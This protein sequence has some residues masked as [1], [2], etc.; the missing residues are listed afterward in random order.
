MLKTHIADVL[1]GVATLR[2]EV[3]TLQ[4]RNA[5]LHHQLDVLHE[6]PAVSIQP[7]RGKRSNASAQALNAQVKK[8]NNEV[9]KLVKTRERDRKR[10]KELETR[11][12]VKDALEL[13]DEE[14]N[15]IDDAYDKMRKLLRRFFHLMSAPSLE[16]KEECIICWEVMSMESV[17]SLPCQHV[18]C[19]KCLSSLEKQEC[20][21]CRASI[22][23]IHDA[24][25][26][27]MTA[28]QQ[29][30]A[31]LEI[32]AEWARIDRHGG[33]D[34]PEDTEEESTPFIDDEGSDS[35]QG[36]LLYIIS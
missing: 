14:E 15:G 32:A 34:E 22:E 23:D 1:R 2:R 9:T 24:E 20:P 21:T 6:S 16:E 26:V 18:L 4:R 25:R 33:D 5:E 28:T 13:K 31:L 19:A 17:R 30:D 36:L 29:W 10:I 11:E 27:E 35:R 7:K 8:L 3:K 12:I